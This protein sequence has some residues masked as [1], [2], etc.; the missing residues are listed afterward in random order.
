MDGIVDRIFHRG[1]AAIHSL[2]RMVPGTVDGRLGIFETI[3]RVVDVMPK[4]FASKSR[5]GAATLDV[6]NQMLSFCGLE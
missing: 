2:G 3:H 6:G 4:H 5:W 1:H